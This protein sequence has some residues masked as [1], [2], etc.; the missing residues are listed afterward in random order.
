MVQL[1]RILQAVWVGNLSE[2]SLAEPKKIRP[3]EEVSE[4]WG[5]LFDKLKYINP[6][7]Y[8]GEA[9]K[10]NIEAREKIEELI[11]IVKLDSLKI[12]LSIVDL[13]IGIG[14]LK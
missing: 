10:G 1:Q 7:Y 3:Q 14:D 5:S 12:F 8:I 11:L 6:K 4:Q 9:I 2:D 13:E